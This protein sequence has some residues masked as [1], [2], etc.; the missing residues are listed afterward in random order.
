[1]RTVGPG[2]NSLRSA[3]PCEGVCRSEKRARQS[4]FATVY[5]AGLD[6]GKYVELLSDGAKREVHGAR[7]T[8]GVLFTMAIRYS[9]TTSDPE[10]HERPGPPVSDGA[11]L[12]R[13]YGLGS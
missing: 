13:K 10:R 8:N 7:E 9:V 11:V 4:V 6:P 3:H 1:M 5:Q 12:S 2:P